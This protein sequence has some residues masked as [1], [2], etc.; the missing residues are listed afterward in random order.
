[1]SAEATLL[2]YCLAIAAIS[3]M[4]GWVPLSLRLTHRR[5]EM[6]ISFVAGAMLGVALLHLLPHAVMTRLESQQAAG[7]T[8]HAVGHALMDPISLWLLAGF[9][10]MFL[11]ERFFCFHHHEAGGPEA[12]VAGAPAMHGDASGCGHHHEHAADHDPAVRASRHRLTWTGAAAGLTLHSL[13]EGV[14]LAAAVLAE[15]QLGGLALPGLATFAVIAL[16]KPFDSLSLVTLMSV[17]GRSAKLRHAINFLFCLVVPL[18]AMLFWFGLADAAGDRAAVVSAAL[19]FS[20]GTFLCISLSDLLPELQFH[21]HDRVKL[22]AMLLLGLTLAWGSAALEG[23][24]HSHEHHGGGDGA[25][26]QAEP[27]DHSD[28]SDHAGHDHDH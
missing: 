10:A 12:A 25:K 18:G 4:G 7:D 8:G 26:R 11:L 13:I 5:L 6:A 2:G 17:G 20:A 3:L 24:T 14:A 23:R 16:H 28:H 15:Q 9:L 27:H 22:S 1:M 19:A 21:Q